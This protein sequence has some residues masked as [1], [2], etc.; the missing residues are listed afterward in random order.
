MN[1]YVIVRCDGAYVSRPGS[2]SSYT[3]YLQQA[4]VYA[5]REQ[6]SRD[7]C[8][9]NERIVSACTAVGSDA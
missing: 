9:G 6:A 2:A 5:T 7:L 4:R 8:P 3:A 1:G